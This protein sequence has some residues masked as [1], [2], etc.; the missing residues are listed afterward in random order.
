M[1]LF[2]RPNAK[3]GR[4]ASLY[5]YSTCMSFSSVED[6]VTLPHTLLLKRVSTIIFTNLEFHWLDHMHTSQKLA[7]GS[8]DSWM[9][10]NRQMLVS[11]D[12]HWL[13]AQMECDIAIE[14]ML[15]SIWQAESAVQANLSR[16]RTSNFI[17]FFRNM[18]KKVFLCDFK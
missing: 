11:C 7:Y 6:V 14:A 18:F 17:P 13:E 12:S 10:T 15:F 5:I 1:F 8:T 9:N 3:R 4:N 16:E 2:K